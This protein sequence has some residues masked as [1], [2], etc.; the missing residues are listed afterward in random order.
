MKKIGIWLDKEKAYIV[1]LENDKENI[2]TLFSEVENFH[3]TSN[4]FLGGSQEILADKK[5]LERE[6]NQLKSYFKKIVSEIIDA[7]AIVIFGPAETG[8][9]FRK[10]LQD[11]YRDLN[12]KIKGVK[13]ADSMTENQVKA[14]VREYFQS[15]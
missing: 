15:N 5:I 11:N 2:F 6:K 12:T 9:K 10:E 14:L 4:Q 1:T 13:K 8:V 3:I 7:D